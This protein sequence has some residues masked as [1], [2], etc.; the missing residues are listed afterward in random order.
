LRPCLDAA[1]RHDIDVHVWKICWSLDTASPQFRWKVKSEGRMAQNRDGTT[2]AWLCPSHP[3]NRKL[4]RDAILE[5]ARNYPDIAGIHLDYLRYSGSS[6]CYSPA[7]RKAFETWRGAKARTWPPPVGDMQFE[8]FRADQITS[9]LADV[10]KELR[11]IAPQMKLSVAV[12]PSYPQVV[13]SIGQD[14]GD[15]LKRDLVDF[16][17]PM[18]YTADL[19]EYRRFCQTQNALSGARG[20]IVPG[21]AAIANEA[22]L[23]AREIM[24]QVQAGREMGLPGFVLFKLDHVVAEHV[25]PLLSAGLTKEK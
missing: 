21:I 3:A 7:T 25:M 6:T 8:K 14:Y 16:L 22:E 19:E 12:W 17:C 11:A 10:R 20:K 24:R 9:F 5:L 18:N 15:W 23:P 4:E 2:K 1:K 13:K